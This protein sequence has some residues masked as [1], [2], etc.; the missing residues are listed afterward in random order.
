MK[1]KRLFSLALVLCLC[2]TVLAAC[3]PTSSTSSG[4]GTTTAPTDPTTQPS[5]TTTTAAP[6]TTTES[7]DTEPTTPTESTQGTESTEP[8]QPSGEET[9]PTSPPVSGSGTDIAA[10]AESLVGTPFEWG[11]A[12]PDS[13]DN[14]GFVYYCYRENGVDL[15]RLTRDMYAAGTAVEEADLQPGDVVFFSVDTPGE[16]QFA[17]IYLRNGL[18]VSSNNEEQPTRVYALSLAYFAERYVGARRY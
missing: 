15:P 11:A 14:S 3:G 9:D 16:A 10:L 7:D 5:Q 18:F 8:T 4:G 6:T 17:G 12:G 13:F 1:S 2:L